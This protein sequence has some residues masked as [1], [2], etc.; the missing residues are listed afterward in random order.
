MSTHAMFSPSA[1]ERWINCPGSV[2]LTKVAHQIATGHSIYTA[3]G[4]VIHAIGEALLKGEDFNHKTKWGDWADVGDFGYETVGKDMFTQAHDYYNA[5]REMVNTGTDI[6]IEVKAKLNDRLYGTADCVLI[7][8]DRLTIIDLKTGAGNM[9]S[10]VENLQLLTYAGL[11]LSGL[12]YAPS[13]VRLVIIQPPDERDP[14]KLWDTNLERVV[15]H[16][17]QVGVAMESE[18][19]EAGHWCQYCPVKASCP[20]MR[21]AA[22]NASSLSLDGLSPEQWAEAL[23]W[24]KMLKPW[25]TEVEKRSTQ[26]VSEAGLVVPGYK[27]VSKKGRLTWKDGVNGGDLIRALPGESLVPLFNDATLRT[28]T[29]LKKEL[30]DYDV[31]DL[32]DELSEVPD[33]GFALVKESDKREAIES[34]DNLVRDAEQLALFS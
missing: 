34:G 7:D 29:Q 5:V 13:K 31:G 18:H 4:T 14:V 28:P 17:N 2:A 24:A 25:C 19:L 21:S 10:P 8:K 12:N 23:K 26:L 9:V 3:S 22:L 16:M 6:R 30:K 1:T 15:S 32:I 33:R 27:L 11:V 20:V